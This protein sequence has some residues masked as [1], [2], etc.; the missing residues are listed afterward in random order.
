MLLSDT[1]VI[2]ESLDACDEAAYD[3][4]WTFKMNREHPNSLVGRQ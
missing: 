3:E 2:V 4:G 1:V